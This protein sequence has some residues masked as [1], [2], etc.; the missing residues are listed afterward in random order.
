VGELE[1][2]Y[3]GRGYGEFKADLADVVVAHL[4][5]IRERYQELRADPARLTGILEAGAA[6]AQAVARENLALAKDRMGFLPRP[7]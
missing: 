4:T 2:A 3:A 1:Q 5:P 6:K 7:A